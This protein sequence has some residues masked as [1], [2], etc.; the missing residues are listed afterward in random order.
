MYIYIYIY[1]KGAGLAP[2][3][4][5]YVAHDVEDVALSWPAGSILAV[6]SR[7]H[8]GSVSVS[9]SVSLSLSLFSPFSV[10]QEGG[11]PHPLIA[12]CG[13]G[14][15]IS[16]QR[17]DRGGVERWH[18]VS[19]LQLPPSKHERRTVRVLCSNM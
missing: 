4:L 3:F 16:L 18:S 10:S 6:S 2:I 11:W 15:A 5:S 1:A 17:E 14:A 19:P 7:S 9:V 8:S 13:K 12:L